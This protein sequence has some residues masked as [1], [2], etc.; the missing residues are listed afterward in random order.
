M[1]L[2]QVTRTERQIDSRSYGLT[3]LGGLFFL[4]GISGLLYEVVWLRM[5]TRLLGNTV[6]ATSTVLAAY[7]GG[8]GIGSHLAGHVV[9]RAGRPL[10]LYAILEL[11]IAVSAALS[12]GL[13]GWLPPIYQG[14]Y[15]AAG[16]YGILETDARLV[17]ALALLLVP[18]TLMGATLP[19]LSAF[20]V[21]R[22]EPF[23]QSTGMLYALNTLGAVSGV[24]L[25]GFVL[26]GS[27][28]ESRT[29]A[30]GIAL[31]VAVALGVVV[32]FRD[33]RVLLSKSV[34][35]DW[36]RDA[37]PYD[38]HPLTEYSARTRRVVLAA[39]TAGG[40]VALAS[41]VVW[42]R[43]LLL[44][45]GASVYAFSAMLA[46]LLAGMGL[47]SLAGGRVAGRYRDPLRLLAHVELAIG[48][49][50]LASLHFYGH[51]GMAKPDLAT[52]QN[53]SMMVAVPILLLGPM[54]FLWGIVFP[55]AVRCYD[56]GAGAR[57]VAALYTGNTLGGIAGALAGGFALVP[58]LGVSI[59]GAALAAASMFL[60]V[61]LLIAHPDGA[62]RETRVVLGCLTVACV[63]LLA[64]VGD[65]YFRFLRRAMARAV[66]N[67]LTVYRH[68]E[69]PAVTT[70]VFGPKNDDRRARH[71]WIDGHGMT[72]LVPVT[73][74]MAHLPLW[75]TAERKDILVVCFGMGTTL[76][77]ASRHPGLEVWA[78]DLD[79]AVFEDVRYFHADGPAL[80]HRPGIHPIVDDGR[81]Y[82]LLHSRQYSAITVDPA[83]PLYS[84]GAVNLYSREFFE[85][86][87]QRLSPG[88]V[89]CL[90][91][92][93]GNASEIKAIMRTFVDV[94]AH[95]GVWESPLRQQSG[96]WGLYL[97]GAAQDFPDIERNVR[98]GFR[99]PAVLAD[100]EEW[101]RECDRPEKVLSLYLADEV[102]LRPWLRDT[103]DISD[104]RPYTEFPL[105]RA[106]RRDMAYS[107]LLDGAK[108]GRELELGTR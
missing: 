7:M 16:G 104:D 31:N 97:L 23:A 50:A 84:A 11:G 76:R 28:G 51:G 29:I 90:W 6:Y 37:V 91:L 85:L 42:G 61:V 5:L 106:L 102:K 57:D 79:P 69:G 80:L 101:G 25:A 58:L 54:G 63:L 55:L 60:G 38:R 93:G 35:G 46:V 21:R 73:K 89:M 98:A 1:T 32:L 77:S 3:A 67:N 14:L 18:T 53:L 19:T 107:V 24:L 36:P 72:A 10:R 40:S 22:P 41:E 95:V 20:A 108:L 27:V 43:M 2:N 8:L 75:L 62:W 96:A 100:L 56:A 45:Q 82:L 52:G 44:Y 4:S 49:S 30:V 103:P 47:G 12:L 65:P 86:C 68:T 74:L 13:V 15:E 26:I 83:P 48:L 87:R 94:F 92:P 78:V 64:T 33:S 70:T 105:W 99:E 39:V 71:L 17:T 59:S 81:S 66:P 88:G 34:N 9:D